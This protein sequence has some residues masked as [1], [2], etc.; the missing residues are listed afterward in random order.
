[1]RCGVGLL[2]KSNMYSVRLGK[3]MTEAHRSESKTRTVIK[4]RVYAS[5]M[6][7]IARRLFQGCV[8]RIRPGHMAYASRV[9]A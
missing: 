9:Y 7:R 2:K 6:H 5:F 1:M 8:S 4:L 3:P